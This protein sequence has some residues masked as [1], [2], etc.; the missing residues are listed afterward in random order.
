MHYL[1]DMFCYSKTPIW[2]NIHV[3]N[4]VR[5]AKFLIEENNVT[6]DYDIL[7]RDVRDMVQF[8]MELATV[9]IKHYNIITKT[10]M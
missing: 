2:K 4:I 7:T 9:S 1:R 5:T 8:Q 10:C 6:V 3:S